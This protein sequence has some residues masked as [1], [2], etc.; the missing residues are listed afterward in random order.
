MLIRDPYVAGAFYPRDARD[1]RACAEPLLTAD[2]PVR[3]ARA[4]ILP[5]AG[6]I[7]SGETACRVLSQVLIPEKN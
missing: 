3:Q 5:H 7:Y 6:Y 4:V 2:K 1:I